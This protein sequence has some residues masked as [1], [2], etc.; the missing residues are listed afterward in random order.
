MLGHHVAHAAHEAGDQAGDIVAGPHAAARAGDANAGITRSAITASLQLRLVAEVVV[1]QRRGDAGLGGDRA[2]RRRGDAL[3]GRNRRWRHR[4]GARA[5]RGHRRPGRPGARPRRAPWS[6]AAGLR[7]F[8]GLVC[9]DS[10]HGRIYLIHRLISCKPE[11][12]ERSQAGTPPGPGK[13]CGTAASPIVCT[14]LHPECLRHAPTRLQ[15][16]PAPALRTGS[17]V[18]RA[19]RARPAALRECATPATASMAATS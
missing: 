13:P 10:C 8:A 17:V 19:G 15:L 16:Q 3:R 18:L 1:Q 11:A 6:P 9:W 12:D 2:Q 14:R 7:A 4:A 5:G